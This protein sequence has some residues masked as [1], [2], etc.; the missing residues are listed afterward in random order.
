[1]ASEE[2]PHEKIEVPPLNLE[3]VIKE[4]DEASSLQSDQ[5]IRTFRQKHIE[6]TARNK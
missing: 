1:M 6:L 3:K 2:G 5:I 4:S